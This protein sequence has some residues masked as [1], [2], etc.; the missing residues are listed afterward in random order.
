MR[1]EVEKGERRK[2]DGRGRGERRMGIY[3]VGG[4]RKG[5]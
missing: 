1:W 4:W 5:D 3:E 2:E